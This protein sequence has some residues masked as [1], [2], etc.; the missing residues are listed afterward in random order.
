M[1]LL[2]RKTGISLEDEFWEALQE[3]A[4]SKALSPVQLVNQIAQS[5]S[6]GNLSSAVRVFL[7]KHFRTQRSKLPRSH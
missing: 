1:L 6:P 5:R 3:V 2:G 4:G 7:L